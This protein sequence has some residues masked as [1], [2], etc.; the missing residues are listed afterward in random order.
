MGRWPG[1]VLGKGR[2]YQ[3]SLVGDPATRAAALSSATARM[4]S[5]RQPGQMPW[6]TSSELRAGSGVASPP[7]R[8][9]PHQAHTRIQI[10]E[11][12]ESAG[13]TSSSF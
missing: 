13:I 9:I 3:A 10:G 6:V 5:S 1:K 4:N 7:G 12:P 2:A 8:E 11:D